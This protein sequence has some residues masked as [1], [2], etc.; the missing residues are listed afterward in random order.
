MGD[1]GGAALPGRRGRRQVGGRPHR[2]RL[3]D[4]RSVAAG[5]RLP[6]PGEA[7]HRASGQCP[8]FDVNSV[9]AGFVFALNV[10]QS[11]MLT[12]PQ[13]YRHVLVI[14]TD[15][16]S[17]IMNWK[18]P[19]HLRLL[20]RRRRRGAAVAVRRRRPA[21]PLPPGERR[22][23]QPLHRGAGRRHAPARQPRGARE[24]AQ[25]LRHGRPQ[26]LGLRRRHGAAD[27]PLAARRAR[28]HA[29]ATSTSW[30]CTR[31]TSACSRRS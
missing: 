6:G 19:A 4:A 12:A 11:M 26:G 29:R 2:R 5:R 9:C 24:A 23:R 25:H 21:H 30:S 18:R 14:G 22:A 16:F 7:G 3:R 8:A 15:A 13:R 31:A 27:D 10:A 20:R 17:K 1:R 28:P